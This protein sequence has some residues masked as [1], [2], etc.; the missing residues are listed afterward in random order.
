M[1]QAIAY[2]V[3]DGLYINMTNRCTCACDFCILEVM[4]Y[5]IA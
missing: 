3:G 1:S 2:T 4:G 5:L